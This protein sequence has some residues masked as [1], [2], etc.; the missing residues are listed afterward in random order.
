MN[1]GS[2]ITLDCNNIKKIITYIWVQTEKSQ[3]HLFSVCGGKDELQTMIE[4]LKHN[5][6]ISME[7]RA[8]ANILVYYLKRGREEEEE[9]EEEA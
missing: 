6:Q 7:F 3:C 4:L 9:V 5:F 1:L 2:Q 8:S